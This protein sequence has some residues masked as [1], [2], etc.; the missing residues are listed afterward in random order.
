MGREL[1]WKYLVLLL[2]LG[3]LL[4]GYPLLRSA[5]GT[6]FLSDALLTIVFLTV[7]VFVFQNR[8]LRRTALVLGVPAL[9][10]LWIGYA[11]P[12]L[13]RAPLAIC[14]HSLATLFLGFVVATILWDIF[15]QRTVT[16]D[17]VF[18]AFCGYLLT[19][20]AFGHIDCVIESSAPGS[21]Q[22]SSEFALRVANPEHQFFLL[23][24]FSLVTL[25][26]VGYGDITPV[27]DAARSVAAV[28]A[29]T[30]QFYVAVVVADLIGKRVSQALADRRPDSSG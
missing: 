14:F 19:A 8:P 10:G 9:V 22:G 30:G 17:G 15:G 25:T 20:L 18:G 13:P 6:R 7:L 4:I 12:G 23:S 26:T 2:A 24:Y 5:L 16:T 29:V 21:F 27:S 11:L 3:M 28:E 1:R